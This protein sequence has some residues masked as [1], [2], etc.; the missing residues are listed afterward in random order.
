MTIRY[1]TLRVGDAAASGK[2]THGVHAGKAFCGDCNRHF[3]VIHKGYGEDAEPLDAEEKEMLDDA[4]ER[5]DEATLGQH[6]IT[7]YYFKP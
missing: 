2:R 7:I 4:A 3:A 5:H 6:N 1:E